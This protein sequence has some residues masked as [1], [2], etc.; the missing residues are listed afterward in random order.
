MYFAAVQ[1]AC[2]LIKENRALRSML[3]KIRRNPA[4]FERYSYLVHYFSCSARF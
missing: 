3:V 1:E 2:E 4:T